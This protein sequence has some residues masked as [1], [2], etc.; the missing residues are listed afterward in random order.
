M[1]DT[2]CA[3]A[4]PPG[5]GGVGVVRVSGD[6]VPDITLR[7][8]GR[9]PAARVATLVTVKHPDGHLID[10]GLA[11]Y[12]PRPASYTGEHILELHLHGN[13][14]VLDETLRLLASLGARLA[15]P[16]EFT[17]RA[18]LNGKMDLVQA[19]AVADLIGSSTAHAARAAAQAMAGAFSAAV[20]D[21]GARL[22][23]VRVQIEAGL[24]FPDEDI[25]PMADGRLRAELHALAA[26]LADTEARAREGR[27]L[28]DGATVVLVGKPNAGKSTLFNALCGNALAIVS[29]LAGTTRDLLR[30]VIDVDGIPVT[31]ID[32]AGL[33]D[34]P[35]D[36]VEF[37]GVRRARTAAAEAQLCLLLVD[38]TERDS[39]PIAPAGRE[40]DSLV[41]YTKIDASGRPP[42]L[43]DGAVAVSA[44]SGAGLD[45]LRAA[46]ALSLR[47]APPGE[48]GFTARRRHIEALHQVGRHL[49]AAIARHE[50]GAHDLA[51]ED[52][53]RAH[54]ALGTIT[55]EFT[56]DE[57]LG[58]IFSSFCIGK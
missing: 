1:D 27:L 25:S 13:P 20:A 10:Q 34:A 26:F 33:R 8:L 43:A 57:L 46:L 49:A 17:E 54:K 22:I 51:A 40:G 50:E 14:V 44:L 19:E 52:L 30:E 7:L 36:S 4:T 53:R 42:G 47:G 32:T 3:I 11:L 29:P 9:L 5:A 16:G 12:F 6:T 38:D 45:A 48:G 58:E 18:F 2:I 35:T 37:E 23:H 28:R 41:V 55:G 21:L 24:D 31:L 15:R 56:T 39:I